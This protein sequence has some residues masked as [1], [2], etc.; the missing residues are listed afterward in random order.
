MEAEGLGYLYAFDDEF[1]AADD[2]Y[3]LD[4]ATNPSRPE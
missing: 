4:T 2:V 1:D 3:R